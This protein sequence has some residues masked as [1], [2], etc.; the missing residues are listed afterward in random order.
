M[1]QEE[2]PCQGLEPRDFGLPRQGW[3]TDFQEGRPLCRG[4]DLERNDRPIGG[5]KD[6]L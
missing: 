4:H 5:G 2:L 3:R 6:G 1:E